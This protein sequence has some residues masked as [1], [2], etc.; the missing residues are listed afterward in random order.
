[1]NGSADERAVK[2]RIAAFPP[3][4]CAN[5]RMLILGSMPGVASLHQ[6]F[7]YA[8]PRNA[9]WRILADIYHAPL[10]ETVSDRIALAQAHGIAL[11]D[12]VE[13]CEREGSLDSAIRHVKIND[14]DQLFARCPDIQKIFFNGGTAARLFRRYA[15]EYLAGRDWA[16]L[17]S[18][19]PA[20]TLSYERKLAQWC[21]ALTD[22]E[23][24]L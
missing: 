11:W 15:P 9:F 3:V 23:Q 10:P 12:V 20:H 21:Q 5:A 24:S 18:T 6:G 13:S 14:F 16:Q 17:P 22:D 7:Y 2:S 1:M 8:H 4:A 19:S